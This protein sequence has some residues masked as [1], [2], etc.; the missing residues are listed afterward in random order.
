MANSGDPDLRIYEETVTPLSSSSAQFTFA[1]FPEDVQLC[2]LSFLTSSEISSFT[3]TSKRF[4]FLCRS[5]GMLWFSMCHRRWGS[6]T[7]IS[8]WGNGRIGF[9][10]LY[11]TLYQWENLIG[12]WRGIRQASSIGVT[13]PPPRLVFFEWGPSFVTGYRVSPSKTGTYQ[14]VKTPFLWMGLSPSGQPL[15]FLDQDCRFESLG[16]FVRVAQSGLPDA[17]LIPVHVSFM[18]KSHFVLEENLG[19]VS[20]GSLLRKMGYRRSSTAN[21]SGTLC[22]SLCGG[23]G[24]DDPSGIGD[25]V[26]VIGLESTSPSHSPISGSPPDMMSEIYQFYANRTIPGS[27][28]RSSR[29]QRKKGKERLGRRKW[30]TEHFV[31]INCTPTQSRPL[32]GLWKGFCDDLSLE[33]Y[34]VAYDDIGGITC[35][36]IGDASEPSS[37]CSLVFWTSDTAF[38]DS[39]FS[40]EEE[41]LYEGRVHIRPPDADADADADAANHIHGC[42]LENDVVSCILNINLSY[43]LVIPDLTGS[44]ANPRHVEGRVWRYTDGTF[45]FGFLRNNVIIDLKHIALDDCLL[46]T[47]ECYWN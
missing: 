4:R 32:Q 5:D 2:I 9:K 34:L 17:D 21:I 31:K 22:T 3:C 12:F 46:D 39:P 26:N 40:T 6:K 41:E 33:F 13:T 15:I 8:K 16:D 23:L 10:L 28:D 36:K 7:H 19:F 44:S 29:R 18:G 25:D 43:D 42:L 37:G 47:T 30:E 27:G 1:D 11:K 38:I 24:G 14:V 35:R 20:E 45:G